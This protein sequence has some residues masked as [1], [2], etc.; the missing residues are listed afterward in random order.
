VADPITNDLMDMFPDTISWE[1]FT[2]SDR[3][4]KELYNPAVSLKCRIG[5]GVSLVRGATGQEVTSTLRVLVPS[6]PGIQLKDRITF[7]S[8]YTTRRPP[9]IT[10]IPPSDENGPHHETIYF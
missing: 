6:T 3:Y 7:P 9:I 2:A 5:Q 10:V 4:G 8:R 1:K